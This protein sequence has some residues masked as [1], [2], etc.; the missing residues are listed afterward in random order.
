VFAVL[1]S[2]FTSALGM[3]AQYTGSVSVPE[4]YYEFNRRWALALRRE[5]TFGLLPRGLRRS[6]WSIVVSRLPNIA[7]A[8]A[9]KALPV[10]R[11]AYDAALSVYVEALPRLIRQ[12]ASTYPLRRLREALEAYSRALSLAGGLNLHPGGVQGYAGLSG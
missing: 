3:R 9:G 2:N 12:H 1:L 5:V 4:N 10:P 11:V 6:Y 7:S 8:L